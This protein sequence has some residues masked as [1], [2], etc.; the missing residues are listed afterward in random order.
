VFADPPLVGIAN[1][2]FGDVE[3]NQ[4]PELARRRQEEVLFAAS[5]ADVEE[6]VVSADVG[7][8]KHLETEPL[9]E[10]FVGLRA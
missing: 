3:A 10:R 5:E 8:L 4:A 9:L 7:R 1:L 2:S 6:D